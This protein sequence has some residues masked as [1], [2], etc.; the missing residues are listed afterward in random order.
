MNDVN[1][2]LR[3][4]CAIYAGAARDASR[5]LVRNPWLALLV[6]AYTALLHLAAIVAGP[7]GFAGGFILGFVLA[8]CASS[9]L[10]VLE[11]ATNHERVDFGA[12][13]G[14]FSRYLWSVVSI[15][16]IFWII[17]FLLSAIIETN[18]G[19][20]WLAVLVNA[21]LFVVCN[22]V[23]ELIYQ[24]PRDGMQLVDEAITFTREN[25]LE[26]LAPVA[27][28]LL[29][30]FALDARTGLLIMSSLGPMNALSY[31][32]IG[33]ASLLPNM[34][35]IGIVVVAFLASAG[36][37]WVMLFRGFLFRVL[38]RSGRRQRIFDARMRGL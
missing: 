21:A 29:P 38:Y 18:A 28:L 25:A 34:G 37:A 5:A 1:I 24:S 3:A 10:A 15:F 13:S 14:S 11:Q 8:A 27:I 30:L 2:L 26:W 31:A 36:V 6:P 22:P 23:P 9:F 17:Q 4:T 12:L 7:L 32:M 20:A 16:F 33:L 35:T 19:L